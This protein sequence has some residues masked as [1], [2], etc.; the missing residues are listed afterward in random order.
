MKAMILAA[1]KGER[2][3]PLTENCP[4]PLIKVRGKPLL[5]YHIQHLA[6]AGVEEIVI[7]VSHLKDQMKAYIEN[8]GPWGVKIHL[9]EEPTL[10]EVGGGIYQALPLLGQKPFIVVNGDVWT[11]Y[12]FSTLPKE[13]GGLAH[14]VL[15]RNPL[16]HMK[17]DFCLKAD[18]TV[19]SDPSLPTYTYSGMS[20]LRPELFRY[21]TEGKFPLAP[22]FGRAIQEQALVG[23]YYA[24]EW[25]DVGTYERLQS[26]ENAL[27]SP[28][29]TRK[30]S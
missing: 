22:L 13:P 24:G 29:L 6:Q 1:G 20:V 27:A 26:L 9:S 7:N 28:Y 3:K 12:N 21:C 19:F 10:L 30:I 5:A 25:T 8:N 14:L 23:E 4:K 16:H 11:D 18:G 2:L 17:G 15:V